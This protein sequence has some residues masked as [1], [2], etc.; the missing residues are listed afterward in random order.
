M[1][2]STNMKNKNKKH[3]G[4]ISKLKFKCH[5]KLDAKLTYFS[6]PYDNKIYT[7]KSVTYSKNRLKQPLKQQKKNI[8]SVKL[9]VYLLINEYIYLDTIDE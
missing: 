2:P 3:I 4:I 9:F 8:R 5:K 6:R 7:Y 1:I